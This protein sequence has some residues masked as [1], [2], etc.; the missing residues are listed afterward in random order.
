[1]TSARRA[2][3]GAGNI[4]P[5]E[6]PHDDDDDDDEEVAKV[7]RNNCSSIAMSALTRPCRCE[8]NNTACETRIDLTRP[9]RAGRSRAK[10][11]DGGNL[12]SRRDRLSLSG[13][14]RRDL[15]PRY[16]PKFQP[17][18]CQ[19]CRIAIK[20]S[21]RRLASAW[22]LRLLRSQ[23]GKSEASFFFFFFFFFLETPDSRTVY[24]HVRASACTRYTVF[25]SRRFSR[26]TVVA[27]EKNVKTRLLNIDGISQNCYLQMKQQRA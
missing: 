23:R 21:A 11:Q 10:L 26:A 5:H 6:Q 24:S 18:V 27:H 17:A 4:H 19:K 22:P 12:I 14:R 15:W 16:A 13:A 1:V 7:R 20:D 3:Q 25:D 9:P 8:F 2:H